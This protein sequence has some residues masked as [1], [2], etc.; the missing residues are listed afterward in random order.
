MSLNHT[1]AILVCLSA[2][3][4][5]IN[6]RF[7]GLPMAIGLIVIALCASLALLVLGQLA[8]GLEQ[9]AEAYIEGID[10]YA[11]LLNGMLNYL[12]FVSALYINLQEL[13]GSAIRAS[14]RIVQQLPRSSR[15]PLGADR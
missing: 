13:R 3:F 4:S 1:L 8:P 11:I 5:Y 10:F 9:A 7:I 14:G 12:L 2:L 6:H 15:C